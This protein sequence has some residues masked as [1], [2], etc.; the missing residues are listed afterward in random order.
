MLR[1]EVW[2][3]IHAS[4]VGML[5]IGCAEKRL[6]RALVAADFNDSHVNRIKPG[7]SKS[8]RLVSRLAIGTKP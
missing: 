8:C 4:P 5:C 7:E 2:N 1:D 3:K 6:G